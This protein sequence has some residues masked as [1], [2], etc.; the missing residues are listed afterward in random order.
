MKNKFTDLIKSKWS[1][2]SKRQIEEVQEDLSKL[3]SMIQETYG[4]TKSRAEMEYHDFQL[5]LKPVLNP[6]MRRPGWQGAIT[7]IPS[8]PVIQKRRGF[9]GAHSAAER[10]N[11]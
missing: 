10:R 2:F 8:R 4:L 1:K 6:A 5:S 7:V 11:K 9:S 3:V